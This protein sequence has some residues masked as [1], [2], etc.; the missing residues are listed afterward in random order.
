MP[1]FLSYNCKKNVPLWPQCSKSKCSLRWCFGGRSL[2][3]FNLQKTPL[4]NKGIFARDQK[5]SWLLIFRASV[6]VPTGT[7]MLS[8]SRDAHKQ[9]G[10]HSHRASEKLHS[11]YSFVALSFVVLKWLKMCTDCHEGHTLCHKWGLM[12]TLREGEGAEIRKDR[13][14][15]VAAQWSPLGHP[16]DTGKILLLFISLFEYTEV[17]KGLQSCQQREESWVQMCKEMHPSVA[18]DENKNW[19]A[20]KNDSD[21]DVLAGFISVSYYSLPPASFSARVIMIMEER[22]LGL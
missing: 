11:A 13:S 22:Q 12:Y 18:A 17:E 4:G 21:T 19:E 16:P 15:T 8:V 20:D 10:P 9:T 1:T 2:C 7:A 6:L 3:L 14:R 5:G